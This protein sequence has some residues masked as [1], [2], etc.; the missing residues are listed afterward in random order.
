MGFTRTGCKVGL[1]FFCLWAASPAAWA[2]TAPLSPLNLNARYRIAWSGITLGRINLIAHE[3]ATRYGMSVDTKTR[4]MGSL[5]SDEAQVVSVEGTKTAEGNY[6][7]VQYISRPL[8][9]GDTD[10]ITLT[11]DTKGDISNRLRMNDDDPAWRPP[12]PFAKINTARDPITA[13]FMLRRALYAAL[14]KGVHEVG[15]RTY[16]GMRLAEMKLIQATDVKVAVMGEYREAVNVAVTRTPIE[17]YTPKELKKF[18]KGDPAIHLYFSND[19][20][21]LPIRASAK[22]LVGELSLTLEEVKE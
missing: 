15:T 5:I 21:F 4:G 16:D 20:A 14:K 1:A 10:L 9:E 12:V 7:P 3:D 22:T 18:K 17:G 8:K 19:A 6:V 13:S 11:Y 2:E